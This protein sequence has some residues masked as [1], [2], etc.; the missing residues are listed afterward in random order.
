MRRR[1]KVIFV[2]AS[3]LGISSMGTFSMEGSSIGTKITEDAATK[4]WG[5]ACESLDQDP[6]GAC[7]TSQTTDC[8]WY[9]FGGCIGQ[10]GFN[11]SKTS[12][13]T[14]GSTYF[15]TIVPQ[16]QC[17]SVIEPECSF[18]RLTC[19]C[20]GGSNTFCGVDPSTYQPCGG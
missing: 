17:A 8:S 7:T 20:W 11:C 3:I 13:M 6:Q 9:L 12:R 18:Y 16:G 14:S 4:L 19:A 10:C 1:R 15:G 2:V 5:G